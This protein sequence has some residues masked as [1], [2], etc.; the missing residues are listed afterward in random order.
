MT[1]QIFLI[2]FPLQPSDVIGRVLSEFS[3]N[4]AFV[5]D[6]SRHVYLLEVVHRPDER[7]RLR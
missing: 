5:P 7:T 2:I 4:T 3:S 1:I 6:D